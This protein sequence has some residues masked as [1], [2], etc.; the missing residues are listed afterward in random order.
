MSKVS[1]LYGLSINEA[2][3]LSDSQVMFMLENAQ[4]T[5]ERLLQ[6]NAAFKQALGQRLAPVKRAVREDIGAPDS[7]DQNID[8]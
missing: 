1:Q 3:K 7:G 2:M 4:L 5:A 6:G 8:F